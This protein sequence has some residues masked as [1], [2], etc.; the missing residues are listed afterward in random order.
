MA[1]NNEIHKLL[2]NFGVWENQINCRLLSI[3][4]KRE[5]MQLLAIAYSQHK[6]DLKS[7]ERKKQRTNTKIG[8][9]N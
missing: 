4:K 2:V 6:K 7:G 9:K 8:K 1:T 5:R 3:V